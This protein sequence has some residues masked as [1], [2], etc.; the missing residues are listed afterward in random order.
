MEKN[1][2]VVYGERKA[3]AEHIAEGNSEGGAGEKQSTSSLARS[4]THIMRAEVK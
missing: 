3:R 4:N 2:S 1:P